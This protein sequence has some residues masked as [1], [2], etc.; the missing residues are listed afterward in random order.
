MEQR[1]FPDFSEVL[2]RELPEDLQLFIDAA[3]S[4]VRQDDWRG[5]VAVVVTMNRRW[6]GK[7]AGMVRYFR[8]IGAPDVVGNRIQAAA[9]A[10]SG[11]PDRQ[12][13]AV[14]Y[15]ERAGIMVSDMGKQ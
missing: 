2:R 9:Y 4:E 11:L 7:I 6:P 8:L 13:A 1:C 10:A 12:W 3:V 15:C 5:I 14:D